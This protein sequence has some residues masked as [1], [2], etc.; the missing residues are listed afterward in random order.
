MP[1]APLIVV[2]GPSGVGKTTV[3][4]RLLA[5]DRLPLRRAVTATSRAPRPGEVPEASYHFWTREQFRRAI[6]E[7]RMIEWEA[8]FGDDFYG[9]PRSEVDPY[10][11]RGT[12]V[13]LVIDVKGAATVR[14]LHPGDHLSVF[15]APPSFEVLEARLRGRQ[16]MPEE[17]V[18]RRLE[19]ARVEMA[20]AETFDRRVVNDEL[21]RAVDEL[22]GLIRDEFNRRGFS[23]CSTS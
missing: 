7:D 13:I 23:I 5:R 21:D 17:K 4:D 19:T 6:D 10:R 15:I 2:S 11:E 20:Q 16:D 22:E 18:L 9:T 3:V 8:V 1:L 14:L 12:G